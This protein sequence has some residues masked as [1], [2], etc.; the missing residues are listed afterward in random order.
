ME[1]EENVKKKLRF[2]PMIQIDID[3]RMRESYFKDLYIGMS[4]C[5]GFF[6]I[7]RGILC[8]YARWRGFERKQ[9]QLSHF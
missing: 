4:S 8:D 3:Q 2:L 1:V 7:L 9:Q 5:K 6:Y